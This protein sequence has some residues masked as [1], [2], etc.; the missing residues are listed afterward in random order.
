TARSPPSRAPGGR[1]RGEEGS[2]RRPTWWSRC[3][4]FGRPAGSGFGRPGPGAAWGPGRSGPAFGSPTAEPLESLHEAAVDPVL[5]P[6]G[7]PAVVGRTAIARQRAAVA[8]VQEGEPVGLGI[9]PLQRLGAE[10]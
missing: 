5:Q 7:E 10:R 9:V 4:G 3:S 2:R 6:P 1:S 8:G